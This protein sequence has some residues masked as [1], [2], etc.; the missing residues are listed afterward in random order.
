MAYS[1]KELEK[2]FKD[3]VFSLD[4]D[5]KTNEL[6]FTLS[7]AIVELEDKVELLEKKNIEYQER[8][9]SLEGKMMLIED[10]GR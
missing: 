2:K 1:N 9:N 5:T 8:I 7:E 6:L 10:D 3:K 4:N